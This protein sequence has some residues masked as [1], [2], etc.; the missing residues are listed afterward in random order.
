MEK[1]G[2]L[3]LTL[4]RKIAL[5]VLI[6][7]F[8]TILILSVFVIVNTIASTKQT[9]I[10]NMQAITKERAQIIESY[11]KQTEDTLTAYSKAGEITDL[12]KDPND[13]KAASLAQKYTENFVK[14]FPDLEGIYVSNWDTYTL[15]HSNPSAVGMTTR[16]GD[17]LKALQDAM[18]RTDGVYNAGVLI[19]PASGQQVVALYRGMFGQSGNPYGLV[20]VAVYTDALINILDNL[21][22]DGMES[23]SYCMLNARDGK[24]IF[25][26]DADKLATVAEETYY[27]DIF[28]KTAEATE[29]IE[30][31]FE[32]IKDG[33]SYTAT[34]YYMADYGWI[35]VVENSDGEIFK[36]TN[37]L[38]KI[39]A[40]IIAIVLIVLTIVTFLMI[41]YMTK[42]LKPIEGS[43]RDL[44]N[45]DIT[46]KKEIDRFVGRKDEL[47]SITA[48][49][50]KLIGTLRNIVETLQE[51]CGTLDSKADELHVSAKQL[52]ECVTDNVATT[53]Q[54]SATLQNTNTIVVDV[55]KEITKINSAISDV[56]DSIVT[57]VD[58]SDGVINSAQ[59]MK[60]EADTAYSN[61]QETLEKTRSSV[62]EALVSLRELSKINELAS[63][64]LSISGQTNLLSLNAS[65]EAARAGETGR[66][67][68]VVAGEIGK[69][70]ETSRDTASAIQILCKDAND[71]IDTVNVC[72]DTI[73]GFI[74]KDVVEQFKDFADK[75]TTYSQKVDSIKSQLDSAEKAV[76]QLS[77]FATQISTNMEDVKLITN[78][79]QLAINAIVE[80]NENTA[81]IANVIQKQSEENKGLSMKL[82]DIIKRFKL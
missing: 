51:C 73:L 49:T 14:D 72:F 67:F 22:I 26:D 6:M 56:L 62:Q 9:A 24:Y 35:F 10:N 58:T 27:Q 4:G 52:T 43:I 75:S 81:E 28:A 30:G 69:L 36:G 32:Y 60:E 2:K 76:Q 15:A 29:D 42:P 53:E 50:K 64:I 8:A 70:A 68:A 13:S 25:T 16:T 5:S 46:E 66:G 12:L 38:I 39:L 79:N 44:Q 55:D 82:E 17:A 33:N 11:V 48:A 61:G 19:S 65:I 71:S 74:E 57:S 77:Q 41:R 37:Q 80:K 3:N 47:G 1:G 54:L 59:S 23:M 45:L 18:V 63:E 21:T 34:Y 31:H 20:G 78:E 40:F 7:Q